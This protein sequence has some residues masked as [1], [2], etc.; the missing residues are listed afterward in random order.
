V[1][2]TCNLGLSPRPRG[3]S[4]AN[5]RVDFFRSSSGH[6]RETNPGIRENAGSI[7]G[8]Y[9]V[10][11]ATRTPFSAPLLDFD[12]RDFYSFTVLPAV[13]RSWWQERRRR[14]AGVANSTRGP[15]ADARRFAPRAGATG[16]LWA[17]RVES[18]RD[19][20][21]SRERARP[22]PH[23]ARAPATRGRRPA[24]RRRFQRASSRIHCA[25]PRPAPTRTRRI[26]D[27]IN[28]APSLSQGH[29]PL[30]FTHTV[31]RPIRTFPSAFLVELYF[32]HLIL[33]VFAARITTDSAADVFLPR[34]RFLRHST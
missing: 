19:A 16:G 29:T 25:F 31:P 30:R 9:P 28:R 14:G 32:T 4:R 34:S 13:S 12:R 27:D 1:R 8:V 21:G 20:T 10:S 24:R 22:K 2:I 6:P 33:L 3:P 11:K 15:E 18:G 23:A 7:A 17:P 5:H 26:H